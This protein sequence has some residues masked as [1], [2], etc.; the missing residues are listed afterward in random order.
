M[1]ERSYTLPAIRVTREERDAIRAQAE[2]RNLSVSEWI[3]KAA[4]VEGAQGIASESRSAPPSPGNGSSP[5]VGEDRLD[6]GLLAKDSGC[7][8]DAPS[9]PEP[10]VFQCPVGG[11]RTRTLSSAVHC[12][13]H[14]RQ[15]VPV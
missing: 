11:C 3:R 8:A 15:V 6:E 2:Q 10:A 13:F 1:P 9:P 14:G 7:Q 12:P 4:G 5:P